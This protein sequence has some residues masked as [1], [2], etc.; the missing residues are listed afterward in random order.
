MNISDLVIRSGWDRVVTPTVNFHSVPPHVD[1]RL[2][3]GTH[4]CLAAIQSIVCIWAPAI[5]RFYSAQGPLAALG[6]V[7]F[8]AESDH[9]VALHGLLGFG[10][11]LDGTLP[12]LRAADPRSWVGDM[13][14]LYGAGQS[15]NNAQYLDIAHNLN[16]SIQ[17][18][19]TE[20]GSRL[21]P[22]LHSRPEYRQAADN[23]LTLYK[24]LYLVFGLS[25]VLLV[26][27]FFGLHFSALLAAYNRARRIPGCAAEAYNWFHLNGASRIGIGAP[28]RFYNP[29]WYRG[30]PRGMTTEDLRI[31]SRLVADIMH[32][33]TNAS[34]EEVDRHYTTWFGGNNFA[35]PMLAPEVVMCAGGA[36]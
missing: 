11:T 14:E 30:T 18:L 16:S 26:Q 21:S 25:H 35:T 23:A 6:Q 3:T 7:I 36:P 34:S 4:A 28:V 13:G 31:D 10:P 24:R 12:Y 17:L 27:I 33:G 32:I 20:F 19:N 15:W 8:S 1:G 29:L 2:G 22:E 9:F 5:R